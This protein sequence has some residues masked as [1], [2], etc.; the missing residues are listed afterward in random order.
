MIKEKP[1]Y[2]ERFCAFGIHD[3][4]LIVDMPFGNKGKLIKTC[5]THCAAYTD[6]W[7]EVTDDGPPYMVDYAECKRGQ[8]II[9]QERRDHEHRPEHKVQSDGEKDQA[10]SPGTADKKGSFPV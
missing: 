7:A 2:K 9:W 10:D 6:Y 5:D 4:I 3:E 1:K 8:F